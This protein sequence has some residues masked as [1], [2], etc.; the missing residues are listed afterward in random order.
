MNRPYIICHMV[1]SIDGKVTGEFLDM[2]ESSDAV[3]VYYEINRNYKADAFACGRIT[4]EGSF[5]GGWYPNLE[6]YANIKIA[7]EDYV[8]D[9]MA[10]F[11][12]VSFDRFGKLG[13]KSSHLI[14]EDP[15][16]DKAHIIEVLC[17]ETSDE[18]L[19]Y[20][21]DIGV[22]YIFSGKNEMNLDLV[23]SKLYSLFGIKTLLLEGG[24]IINGAVQI[25]NYIDELSL[26][27]SPIV[28]NSNDKPLF[29]NSRVET[30]YLKES[31]VYNG[32]V[33][34]LNYKKSK[35]EIS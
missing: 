20:L 24:S 16:Y 4:M 33:I 29:N 22:S 13:W 6:K 27:V 1:T 28:S 12:A 2:S 9:N 26:V 31:K 7:R 35:S 11:Y 17:E 10:N 14:D 32:N 34:W 25:E 5:T 23:F 21:K 18:Y 19:A 30:Y 8:A 3:S 15:G